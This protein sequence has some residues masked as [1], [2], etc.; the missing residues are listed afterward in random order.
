VP[1]AL[2]MMNGKAQEMLT[3]KDSLIFRNMEK[4]K[5]PADKAEAVFL[6]LLNRKPT[7]REK[8]IAKRVTA[9]GE[10]GY[11]DMIWALVNSREFCFVQ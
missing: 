10:Q 11:A 7:L 4:V 1:Q 8:D 3:N 6:S 5:N 9:E 2:M